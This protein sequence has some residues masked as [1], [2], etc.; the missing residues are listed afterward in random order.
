MPIFLFVFSIRFPQKAPELQRYA[1]VP[2]VLSCGLFRKLNFLFLFFSLFVQH[3]LFADHLYDLG[4]GAF[5]QNFCD[6]S[7][8]IEAVLQYIDFNQFSRLKCL[9]YSSGMLRRD[10]AFPTCRIGSMVMARPFRY[11]LCLLVIRLL[12]RYL[13]VLFII[14]KF[15]SIHLDGIAFLD[16]G[17]LEF[18]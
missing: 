6:L 1:P 5:C 11:A 15:K 2:A 13:F 4:I 17:L 14:I 3:D 12:L 10:A 16:A 7:W 18:V 9:C 8:I